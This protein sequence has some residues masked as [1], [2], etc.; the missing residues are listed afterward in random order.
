MN[1]LSFLPIFLLVPYGSYLW[2]RYLSAV[3]SLEIERSPL[4]APHLYNHQTL[5]LW[6]LH[7]WPG[8]WLKPAHVVIVTINNLRNEKSHNQDQ[9]SKGNM[10]HCS[11]QTT[12]CQGWRWLINV[13]QNEHLFPKLQDFIYFRVQWNLI[14]LSILISWERALFLESE[15]LDL[16]QVFTTNQPRDHGQVDELHWV[17]FLTEKMKQNKT[18]SPN[19]CLIGKS[20]ENT[21]QKYK[22]PS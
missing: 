5:P 4:T 13:L 12:S 20:W 16:S 9:Q 11:T 3:F 7:H 6:G 17:C 14:Y 22:I 19:L 15:S 18:S 21:L 8:V 10:P 1:S 2:V